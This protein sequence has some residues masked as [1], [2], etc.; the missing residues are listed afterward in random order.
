MRRAA[1]EREEIARTRLRVALRHAS[2][3]RC[4]EVAVCVPPLLCVCVEGVGGLEY[5]LTLTRVERR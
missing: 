2:L 3:H 5:Y 1:E 4:I